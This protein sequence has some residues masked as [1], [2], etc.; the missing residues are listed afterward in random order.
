MTDIQ[1]MTVNLPVVPEPPVAF[2]QANSM[3]RIVNLLELLF[4]HSLSRM[5]LR[6]DTILMN[7]RRTITRMPVDTS[8][9]FKGHATQT[10][11]SDS[12]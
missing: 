7:D 6:Q 10:I 12:I 11:P 9:S 2:P 8:V 3:A 1:D 5:K 4:L